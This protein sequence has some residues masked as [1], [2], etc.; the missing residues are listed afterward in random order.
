LIAVVVVV[1][2]SAAPGA[3]AVLALVE[4][5]TAR[6]GHRS[7]EVASHL[8]DLASPESTA[9]AEEVAK[10][11]PPVVVDPRWA[12]AA[13]G[14]DLDEPSGAGPTR[15]IDDEQ[16][17]VADDGDRRVVRHVG[18]E[19]VAYCA[20]ELQ[21]DVALVGVE[22]VVVCPGFRGVGFLDSGVVVL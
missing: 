16:Q 15:A 4:E 18:D 21:G 12:S 11:V 6:W 20:A 5:T 7:E 2:V 14:A 13:T 3:V 10:P 17:V 1:V 22:V 9:L 8:T 19:C